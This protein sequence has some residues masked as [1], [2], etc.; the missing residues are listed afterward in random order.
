MLTAT[1][2]LTTLTSARVLPLMRSASSGVVPYQV[3]P[4]LPAGRR[5]AQPALG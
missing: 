5:V 1:P 4:R 3:E 2:V